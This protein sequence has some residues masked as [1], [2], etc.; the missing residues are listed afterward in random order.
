M[1]RERLL[2]LSGWSPSR[3]A[4]AAILPS[5]PAMRNGTTTCGRIHALRKR[6]KRQTNLSW[7]ENG[8]RDANSTSTQAG[9]FWT[10]LSSADVLAYLRE[11]FLACLQSGYREGK[12][13][14]KQEVVQQ[15]FNEGVCLWKPES[16]GRCCVAMWGRH[17]HFKNEWPPSE[18]RQR[19]LWARSRMTDMQA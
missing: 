3:C 13:A 19:K 12:D 5:C 6:L 15:A 8:R 14:G 9:L 2:H 18:L 4:D 7:T 11:T 16:L 10:E 17:C 1:S